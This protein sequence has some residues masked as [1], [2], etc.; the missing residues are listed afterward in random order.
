[1][2]GQIEFLNCQTSYIYG[3][4]ATIANLWDTFITYHKNKEIGR[5]IFMKSQ[6]IIKISINP[7]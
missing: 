3:E 5:V 2:S 1:M 4:M 7:S 6:I